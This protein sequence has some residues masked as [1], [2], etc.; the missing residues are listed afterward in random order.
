MRGHYSA[1]NLPRSLT[2]SQFLDWAMGN[3]GG[4]VGRMLVNTSLYR[5]TCNL[6]PVEY[7]LC[8]AGTYP[9]WWWA[10]SSATGDF[11]MT[12]PSRRAGRDWSRAGQGAYNLSLIHI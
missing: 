5:I 10:A 2:Q 3:W 4:L 12:C 11:M 1:G 8:P 7:D 6:D 9:S